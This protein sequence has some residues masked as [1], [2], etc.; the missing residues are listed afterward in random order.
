MDRDEDDLRDLKIVCLIL[1]SKTTGENLGKHY[2]R[3]ESGTQSSCKMAAEF[4]IDVKWQLNSRLMD[5]GLQGIIL[6][7]C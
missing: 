6:L 4:K 3:S 5:Q 1:K 7:M 2:P